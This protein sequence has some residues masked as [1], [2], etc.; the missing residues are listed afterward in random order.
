MNCSEDGSEEPPPEQAKMIRR[1][2]HGSAA[3]E[4]AGGGGTAAAAADGGTGRGH[5]GTNRRPRSL[6]GQTSHPIG[7]IVNGV[8][9]ESRLNVP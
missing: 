5:G 8:I 2:G 3:S 4:S 6:D 1:R 9:A 7:M